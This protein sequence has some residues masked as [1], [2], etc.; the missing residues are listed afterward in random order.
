MNYNLT[1]I[2]ERMKKPRNHGI[3]MVMDKGLSMNEVENF[4]SVAG[5]HVDIVKFVFGQI[6][7]EGMKKVSKSTKKL[8]IIIHTM[9]LPGLIWQQH[10]RG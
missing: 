6:L 2:P 4:L 9:K 7:P 3:T 10:F 5:P 1:Q 8:S